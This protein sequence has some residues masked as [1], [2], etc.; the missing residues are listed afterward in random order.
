[1][2]VFGPVGDPKGAWGLGVVRVAS[3]E[4]LAALCEGDPAIHSKR[5]FHYETLPMIQAVTRA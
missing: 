1:V 4:K 2:V 5:G 3:P